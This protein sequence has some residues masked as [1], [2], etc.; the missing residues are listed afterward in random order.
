MIASNRLHAFKVSASFVF[1]GSVL[2]WGLLCVLCLGIYAAQRVESLA[3]VTVEHNTPARG[4]FLPLVHSDDIAIIHRGT[5]APVCLV[6]EEVRSNELVWD[7]ICPLREKF[8]KGNGRGV[9]PDFY[10]EAKNL[11]QR[12]A[13]IGYFQLIFRMHPSS[14]FLVTETC[15]LFSNLALPAQMSNIATHWNELHSNPGPF[16]CYQSIGAGLRSVR[17]NHI[18]RGLFAEFAERTDTHKHASRAYDSQNASE[19]RGVAVEH[20][21]PPVS[22]GF[23]FIYFFTGFHIGFGA[24]I[25]ALFRLKGWRRIVLLVLGG[26]LATSALW[27][28]FWWGILCDQCHGNSKNCAE[29]HEL[30]PPVH[31]IS[32]PQQYFLTSPIYWNTVIAI[33]RL[34]M[35]NTLSS[36]KQVTVISA[37]AEG[38]AIRQI[39][40]MTGVHR[41]TI[42]RLGVR[43]GQ[44]CAKLMD[45][46]MR[47]LDCRYLQFDE[48]WG[49]IN[50]KERHCYDDDPKEWGDVW[51]FCAIDSD[52]KLV[53]SFKCGKRDHVTA[54]AFVADVASRMRNRVQISADALSAYV[55]AVERSFGS[56][57]DF[58]QIIKTYEHDGSIEP[59]RKWSAPEVT[60][61]EK[62]RMAGR[63]NMALAST[64]HVERLNGTTRLHM[65][66][67][68]R[69][70]YAFSKKF[71]N[72]E[73][74][75]ALHFAYYNF[76]KRHISLRCTP[77]MAAGIERDF[78]SVRNLVEAA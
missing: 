40:R 18:G 70:T 20:S 67:L 16:A 27:C 39:E 29:R 59:E 23:V 24:A 28:P 44:G 26:G 21:G 32:V 45:E 48:I 22:F 73:A 30:N 77:A 7:S 35:A 34:A 76:C 36:D 65:R 14:Y 71:E 63:P 31:T 74:S 52:T 15:P 19:Q 50:K 53:P 55:E 47:D 37:L 12:L 2:I 72:F 58:A 33:E 42:M 1:F 61:T 57:V 60:I 46:K 49:F 13:H 54:N 25:F 43:V 3:A 5:D 68:T 10:L 75:C 51:T 17:S 78:W 9:L 4:A 11:C 56:E 38:S 41:D 62:R 8:V 69:L 66:R 6:S 64:S